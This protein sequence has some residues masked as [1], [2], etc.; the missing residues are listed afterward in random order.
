MVGWVATAMTGLAGDL[1]S[2]AERGDA[3]AVQALLAKG[4][5]VNAKGYDGWTALMLASENGHLDVVQALLAKGPDLNAKGYDGRTALMLTSES[6]HLDVAQALLAKG[7][8]LLFLLHEEFPLWK[9]HISAHGLMKWF[10]GR[11]VRLNFQGQP[12]L[13]QR[14]VTPNIVDSLIGQNHVFPFGQSAF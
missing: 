13:F 12:C 1:I 11:N 8:D 3:A 5:E 14:S 10:C 2:A 6:G 4:A 7:P 9:L